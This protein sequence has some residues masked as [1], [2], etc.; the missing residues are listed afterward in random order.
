M[1]LA[2]PPVPQRHQ[3]GGVRE[4]ERAVDRQPKQ[5][6]LRSDAMDEAVGAVLGIPKRPT[7]VIEGQ[8]ETR[9]IR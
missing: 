7:A 1:R 5:S 8:R 3:G 9:A 2:A 6:L 4:N